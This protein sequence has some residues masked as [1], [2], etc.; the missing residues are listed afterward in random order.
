[1]RWCVLLYVLLVRMKLRC[2]W[3]W[4]GVSLGKWCVGMFLRLS[5]L[6]LRLVCRNVWLKL[7]MMKCVFFG[8]GIRCLWCGSMNVSVLCG[9]GCVMLL[10]CCLVLL[11][12]LNWIW[13]YVC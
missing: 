8:C 10:M 12:R 4:N 9:N 2:F 5:G 7:I 3:K 6:M 13:K 1:M 11:L